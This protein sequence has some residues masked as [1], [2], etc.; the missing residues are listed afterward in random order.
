MPANS[1]PRRFGSSRTTLMIAA[2]GNAAGDVRP[3]LAA[4]ARAVD[5]RPQVVEADRVDRR[6]GGVARRSA[7]RPSATPSPTASS[8]GGVTSFQVLPPSRVTWIRPSSVPAQIGLL[9]ERTT[10]RSCRSRRAASAA[11][12]RRPAYMPTFAGTSH[13]SRVR[14]GLI[15]VPAAARRSSSSRATFD[16]KYSL[17]GLTG[18]NSTGCVRTTR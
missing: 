6:V 5:V 10:A 11:L 18:E 3:G 9:V 15:C 1:S 7:T 12:R 2:V 14:S 4:V 16:A 8:A 17:R 13:V